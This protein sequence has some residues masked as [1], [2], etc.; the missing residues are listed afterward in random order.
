MISPTLVVDD[1]AVIGADRP[2]L[3]VFTSGT[4]GPPKGVVI[5]RSLLDKNTKPSKDFVTLCC[6]P[7]NHLGACGTML[8]TIFTG[9]TLDIV[10]R[11]AAVLWERLC[12][13]DS[14]ALKSTPPLW[15]QMMDVFQERIAYLPTGERDQYIRGLRNLR[16][17]GIYG[18]VA[19]PS[20]LKFWRDLGQTL[21]SI[22]GSTEAGGLVLMSTNETN[23]HL[24][25]Y[26]RASPLFPPWSIDNLLHLTLELITVPIYIRIALEDQ[27]QALW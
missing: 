16:S 4:T 22:Y 2:C 20:L 5:P 25:V 3:V 26:E 13:W 6:R 18:A 11:D 14:T 21:T 23:P 1:D 24:K 7:P 15:Q 10:P 12:K 9:G 27:Y 17:A 19:S 8:S